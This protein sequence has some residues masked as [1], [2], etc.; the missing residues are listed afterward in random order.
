MTHFNRTG[1]YALPQMAAK[2]APGKRI[3]TYKSLHR[4]LS[5]SEGDVAILSPIIQS[6][7]HLAMINIPSSRIAAGYRRIPLAAA[8]F[9]LLSRFR[10][11]LM[12][13][14]AAAL[15]PVLVT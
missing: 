4:P 7:A 12:K 2:A 6:A 5:S 15:S 11:F 9:A 3:A 1:S 14:K 8:S 13:V 10:G